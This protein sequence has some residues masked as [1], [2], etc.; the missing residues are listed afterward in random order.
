MVVN[1]DVRISVVR[2]DGSGVGSDVGYEV[3]SCDYVEV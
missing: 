2:Y 1:Y 3:E